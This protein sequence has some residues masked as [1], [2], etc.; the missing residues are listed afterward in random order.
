METAPAATFGASKDSNEGGEEEYGEAG[1]GFTTA[2]VELKL[3]T[4]KLVLQ[5]FQ[6]F[7]CSKNLPP[8]LEENHRQ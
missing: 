7:T 2:G 8:E 1:E 4:Q 5:I 6:L 3:L